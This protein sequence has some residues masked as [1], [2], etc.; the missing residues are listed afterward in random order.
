MINEYTANNR[1][2]IYMFEGAELQRIELNYEKRCMFIES[3]KDFLKSKVQSITQL[4]YQ[5]SLMFIERLKELL[6]SKTQS[7]TH[8]NYQKSLMF[9]KR[10][11]EIWKK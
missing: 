6:K 5:K 8:L 1:D 3:S 10:L 9:I 2:I 11:K 7:I 4:N